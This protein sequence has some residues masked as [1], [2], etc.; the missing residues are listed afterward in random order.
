MPKITVDT[1]ETSDQAIRYA[2]QNPCCIC[3]YAHPL[4]NECYA[5]VK[6][7]GTCKVARILR[8]EL[9]KLRTSEER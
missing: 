4:K 3:P 9:R 7:R 6:Y 5:G 8:D 2:R 1:I